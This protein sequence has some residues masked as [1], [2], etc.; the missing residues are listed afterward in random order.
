M[1][2]LAQS[3]KS[4]LPDDGALLRRLTDNLA[5]WAFT[6]FEQAQYALTELGRLI[7]PRSPFDVR[8]SYHRSAAFLENQWYRY[9]QSLNHAR[10][11]V[12]ILES[13]VD[14]WALAEI[15]VDIAATH[16]NQRDWSAAEDAIERAKR[17]L[18]EDAPARLHAHISCREGFFYLHLANP[19]KALDCLMEA[20][21]DLLDLDEKNAKLKDWYI[22]TLTLSGLGE[23]YEYL[24]EE[25]KSQEAYR[26]ILPIVEKYNLRPRLAWHYLNAGRAA[27]ARNE[28]DLAQAHFEKV[29]NVAG[30][31]EAEAK[32]LALSNLGILATLAGNAPK[33][34]NLFGQ[35]ASDYDP[36]EKPS[37]FTNLSKIES[38][39]A[40][41][42]FQLNNVTEAERHYLRAWE[43]GK[44]G[45]DYYH[46]AQV[47]QK[48]ASLYESAANYQKAY[49]W[50]RMVTELNQ[51]FFNRLRD[52]ER[53]EIEAR[54]QLERSRQESKIARLRVAGLQLRALRAQMNPHF[55]FNSLNAIQGLVTSG[56]NAE[57]ESYLAKFA[58]MMRHTL[59][60]SELEEVS[61]EQEIEFLERYLDINRKLR[62]RDR[63]D[64]Q[65][66]SPKN[67]E[68]DELFVPTMIVQPFVENAIE[69]G[70][71]PRQEG[72]LIIRFEVMPEDE[73]LLRCTIEDDGVGINKGREKQAAQAGAGFQKHRSRGMEITNERLM[74]LHQIQQRPGDNFIQIYDLADITN[75]TRSGTRVE[76]LLP[77]LNGE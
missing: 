52:N 28:Q 51:T 6:D 47:S 63:L 59:E 22:K 5:R 42:Y 66:I 34:F 62:F 54:H 33:A 72:R 68:L 60:Y 13:L 74:L 45:G 73:N 15:W 26:S 40:G 32:T 69:H 76:V 20:E 7:T 37:D 31:G 49:E 58:K 41:L 70:L 17:Y 1:Q 64:F 11:A 10:Q 38:W 71:R 27:L 2:S 65:V 75:G 77:I 50:Q 24:G 3:S 8:L 29:L 9:E 30:A 35:A 39:S 14:N 23:L 56:R 36:P 12:A 16:L 55:M 25:E 21:K 48:L 43:I 67:E 18:G 4:N 46:L 53:Q 61:L 57:A 44:K 19:R